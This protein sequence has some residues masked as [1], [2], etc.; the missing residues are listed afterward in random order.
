MRPPPARS[1]LRSEKQYPG[2]LDVSS[3]VLGWAGALESPY[4]R[5]N[6]LNLCTGNLLSWRVMLMPLPCWQY[7]CK[8]ELI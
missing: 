5:F 1:H 6:E 3:L 2:G 4:C 8:I 7:V